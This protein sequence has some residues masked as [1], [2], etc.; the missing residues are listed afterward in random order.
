MNF[1]TNSAAY[2]LYPFSTYC[3]KTSVICGIDETPTITTVEKYQKR[4]WSPEFAYTDDELMTN[5]TPSECKKNV[6]RIGDANCWVHHDTTKKFAACGENIEWHIHYSRDYIEIT[7]DGEII[8]AGFYYPV[9]RINRP[10]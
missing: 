4:G 9:T 8:T 3:R 2:S 10:E 1:I 6:R 5:I 7:D